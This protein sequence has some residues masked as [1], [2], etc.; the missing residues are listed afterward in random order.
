MLSDNYRKTL[1]RIIYFIM[2]SFLSFILG[3]NT[4]QLNVQS[5]LT[6][7]HVLAAE[8]DVFDLHSPDHSLLSIRY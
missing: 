6:Q 7:G 5:S 3:C 2:I 4:E 1:T 8:P